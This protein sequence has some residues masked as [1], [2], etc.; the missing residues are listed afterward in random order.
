MLIICYIFFFQ[1]DSSVWYSPINNQWNC[2]G[3]YTF[4]DVK[5]RNMLLIGLYHPDEP[6][7]KFPVSITDSSWSYSHCLHF[8]FVVFFLD[9]IFIFL[10]SCPFPSSFLSSSPFKSCGILLF[11]FFAFV[12]FSVFIFSLC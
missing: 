2:P 12:I 5:K 9:I 3:I 10:W 7:W 8:C 11:Y 6:I 1:I 4:M